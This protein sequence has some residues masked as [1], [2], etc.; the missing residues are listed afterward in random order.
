[1]AAL[2]LGE[3]ARRT[4]GKI[5]QGSPALEIRSYGIDSRQASP[6]ELFFAVAGKR[7]G[8][9][10]IPAAMDMGAAGAVVSRPV[11]IAPTGFGLVQVPDVIA[12]LQDLARSVLNDLSVKVVGITGS[13]G[14]TTTKEFAADLLSSRLSVLKSE[15]NFNNHLGLALSLLRVEPGHQ[16]VVLEMGMNS[17]GEI[18]ALTRV[19]PP[20]VAVITNVRPVHLQYFGSLEAIALAK[21]EILDGAKSGAAAVLNADDPLVMRIAEGYRGPKVTFGLTQASD[22]RAADLTPKGFEGLEF[23]LILGKENARVSFPFVNESHVPNLLAAIAVCRTLGLS[24]DDIVPRIAGLKPFSMRGVLMDL[25]GEI[26]LFDDSY[27]S[28]PTAL[29]AALHSLGVLRAK[30]KVAVLA[31][32]LELGDGAAEFHRQ[33]GAIVVRTGWDILVTVGPLADAIAD[34]AAVAGMPHSNVHSY[35]DSTAAAEAISDL[36]REGDLV[37]VK[38]SR[39]MKTEMIVAKLKTRERK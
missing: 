35:A 20:D 36:V 6:G 8:H 13:I 28:S 26:R 22:V 18:R 9:D 5:L 4:G 21:K 37:L 24:L 27:N 17:P 3:I 7:D 33:A 29:E 19:A 12:A 15:G 39:G 34:G 10:F 23:K 14:K 30:R 32:M 25:V 16:V 31:D 38:G 2:N 11:T 1:M